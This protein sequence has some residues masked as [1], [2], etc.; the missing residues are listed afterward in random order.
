MTRRVHRV[1]TLLICWAILVTGCRPKQ[2]FY[3]FDDGD[4]SHYRGM[5]TELETPD[6]NQPHL[7]DITESGS[8]P[9]LEDTAKIEY[10]DLTLE[11]AMKNALANS[12]VIRDIGGALFTPGLPA[13]NQNLSP[14]GN[15]VT[16]SPATGGSNS[17]GIRT[18]YDPAFAE[19]NPQ[20]G[21]EAALSAFDAQFNT[22]LFWEKN[23]RPVNITRRNAVVANFQPFNFQQDQGTFTAELTKATR[24]GTRLFLRTNE[25]YDSNTN[26]S[27]LYRSSNDTNVEAEV[28]H[29]LLQGFGSEFNG[30][31]GPNGFNN[32][33][34]MG[35]QVSAPANFSGVLL[36][37]VNTDIALT[38]FEFGVRQLVTN[39]ER[40]YWDL[41]F[42]YRNLQ[43]IKIGYDSALETWRTVNERYINSIKGG[44]ADKEAQAREQ[45]FLFRANMES[46]WRTVFTAERRLRYMMGIAPTDGRMIRPKDEPTAARVRFD[47][48]EIRDEG[49]ARSVEL[50]R[51]KWQVKSWELRLTGAR[52]YLLPRL[53][54]VGRYRW[55][56]FG[57]DLLT[58]NRR[59]TDIISDP[60]PSAWQTLTAGNF[61]EWQLGF[62]L[63][64]PLG[65]RA[66]LAAVRN[67]E[68]GLARERAILQDQ[69]LELAHRLANAYSDVEGLYFTC[70]SQFNRRIA[71]Q[72]NVDALQSQFEAD[73]V[74]L[75]AVLE[76]QR[77]LA[78]AEI[79][80]FR[81]IVDYNLAILQ[82]HFTKGSLLEYNGVQLA[83]GPWP[84]KAYFDARRRAR[85][86]DSGLYIDYGLTRPAVISRG[87]HPQ[88]IR[89]ADELLTSPP[90]D[91]SQ[92]QPVDEGAGA[93]SAAG[94]EAPELESMGPGPPLN[95]T[96]SGEADSDRVWLDNA[97]SPNDTPVPGIE[98]QGMIR[99]LFEGPGPSSR[100]E[101]RPEG[102]NSIA[103]RNRDRRGTAS[104]PDDSWLER[105][106]EKVNH[107]TAP[108]GDRSA[109]RRAPRSARGTRS[110]NMPRPIGVGRL[111]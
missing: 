30:I 78:D 6:V 3:F 34:P 50:R 17:L 69:E 93:L 82:I 52:N 94:E 32:S 106:A 72:R 102:E 49:L 57:D 63:S 111:N 87:P 31:V 99:P 41:Y 46:A 7:P 1:L 62:Q 8:P 9:S 110:S 48:N 98:D 38:D 24:S 36:A 28:R 27:N 59:P 75:D 45:L 88:K 81:A 19:S 101:S 77:R 61:Q 70:Q 80:Y 16:S 15:L 84:G 37:R 29:P 47:F 13:A 96:G 90:I 107:E 56:G 25:T 105:E 51:Q 11:E 40:A 73:V 92:L 67:A 43:A 35:Q 108:A 109:S 12:K 2:P 4:M 103:F 97:T 33:G 10:W 54:A 39:V 65:F 14:T 66:Q 104:R 100:P 20:G 60:F 58:S 79:Q 26:P 76:A 95:T 89:S 74:T 71:A 44:E 91:A 86:R 83:E 53:D 22:R 64:V 18:V 23:D 21:V 55:R 68:I 42:Q 85:E 5:A